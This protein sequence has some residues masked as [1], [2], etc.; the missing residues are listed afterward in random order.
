MNRLGEFWR[1]PT[2]GKALTIVVAAVVGFSII[3]AI[4]SGSDDDTMGTRATPA[5]E[6][7]VAAGDPMTC[8]EDAGLST[9]ALRDD[10][11]LRG[12]TPSYGIY[13][14]VLASE[15]EARQAVEDAVDV[16]AA[17]SGTYAVTGPLKAGIEGAQSTAEEGAE[18][19][20]LV[21][22]VATCL[23]G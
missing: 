3:G 1:E 9:V 12:L 16:Y 23:D 14:H 11:L 19:D 8:L 22:E 20:A 15:A 13:V 6:A 5:T 7:E 21:Q 10:D 4:T 17:Q 2:L 18:A